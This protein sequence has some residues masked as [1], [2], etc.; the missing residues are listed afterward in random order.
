MD[1]DE[2]ELVYRFFESLFNEADDQ[3]LITLFDLGTATNSFAAPWSVIEADP[4]PFLDCI[5]DKRQNYFQ[6]GTRNAASE[7]KAGNKIRGTKHDVHTISSVWADIDIQHATRQDN[8]Q[9]PTKDLVELVLQRMPLRPSAIVASGR[10]MHAYWFLLDPIELKGGDHVSR[11]EASLTQAWI[12]FFRTMLDRE[13]GMSFKV[14]KV[15]DVTRMMRTPGSFNEKSR[16]RCELIQFDPNR[17][18]WVDDL[19]DLCVSFADTARPI[20]EPFTKQVRA[21]C[22]SM[23]MRVRSLL[24]NHAD[25]QLHWHQKTRLKSNSDYCWKLGLI[26]ANAG[27]NYETIFDALTYWQIHVCDGNN[28]V[29]AR[30]KAHYTAD[31]LIRYA[32]AKL[33]GFNI[34][35]LEEY[36]MRTGQIPDIE[37]PPASTMLLQVQDEADLDNPTESELR[38]SGILEAPDDAALKALEEPRARRSDEPEPA[39]EPE[40][41]AGRRRRENRRQ[42]HRDVIEERPVDEPPVGV[43]NA[44]FDLAVSQLREL[45]MLNFQKVIKSGDRT[46]GVYE[47]TI[48][49]SKIF[50]GS[51]KEWSTSAVELSRK[52]GEAFHGVHV[53]IKRKD[54]DVVVGSIRSIEEWVDTDEYSSRRK[55]TD[56]LRRYVNEYVPQPFAKRDQALTRHKPYFDENGFLRVHPG[57]FYKFVREICRIDSLST[58][59]VRA[60]FNLLGWGCE[61]SHSF[62]RDPTASKDVITQMGYYKIKPDWDK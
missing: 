58:D 21:V 48:E 34:A 17:R 31:K 46:S 36:R 43:N 35:A 61:S 4:E 53:V 50:M 41:P 39:V 26:M 28:H 57:N 38:E 29:D 30:R 13:A 49:G 60:Q 5:I 7:V 59:D 18:Y 51:L 45:T 2:R 3:Q 44:R 54:L 56:A 8:H 62:I 12:S 23:P 10:G 6:V 27:C 55:V 32:S 24:I 47:M 42:L 40:Q 14:D 9:Y 52:L 37:A 11:V 25:F 33:R 22:S 16:S 1:A 20:A 19:A 15:G